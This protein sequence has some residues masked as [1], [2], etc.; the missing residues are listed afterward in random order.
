[1]SAVL[2]GVAIYRLWGR[3]YFKWGKK[4]GL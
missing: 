4:E 1:L 3:R 2:A